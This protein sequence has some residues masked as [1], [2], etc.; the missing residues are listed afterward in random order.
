MPNPFDSDSSRPSDPKIEIVDE[1]AIGDAIEFTNSFNRNRPTLA[2]FAAC[3][4]R[5]ELLVVRDAF[6]LGLASDLCPGE[7][8][9]A[10]M[11]IVLDAAVASATGTDDHLRVM[12]E[13]ARE[14]PGWD[15]MV[16]A[17]TDRAE[18][19]GSD[20][21]GIWATLE[22]GRLEW[23][24]A[25]ST[26]H[27]IKV[28]LKEAL[29]GESGATDG[30]VSDAKMVWIYAICLSVPSLAVAVEKWR[31]VVKMGER[32]N[33]LKGYN[34]ALWD[35]RKDEWSPLDL[36]AQAAAEGGGSSLEEAWKISCVLEKEKDGN[37]T[38]L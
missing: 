37:P 5:A 34:A 23:L 18:S 21:G 4:D 1:R 25:V 7:Y 12:I 8:E 26:A 13:S 17:V 20:L 16:R 15:G 33:P 3:S 19:V 28:V 31:R 24:S 35:C 14:S 36:G 32:N 2:G 38:V 6:Y 27:P 9:P 10:R 30:D 11:A 22:R 29:D